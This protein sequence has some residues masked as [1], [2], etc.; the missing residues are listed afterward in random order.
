MIL[1]DVELVIC[2]ILL[3]CIFRAPF[4]WMKQ[5]PFSEVESIQKTCSN[6]MELWGY[7]VAHYE[8]EYKTLKPLKILTLNSNEPP[9]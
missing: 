3:I 2:N 6:A 4:R 9:Q 7:N 1:T 8:D 5:M